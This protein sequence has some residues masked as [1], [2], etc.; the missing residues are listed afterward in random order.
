VRHIIFTISRSEIVKMMRL[1]MLFGAKHREKSFAAFGGSIF[2]WERHHFWDFAKRNLKN[3]VSLKI[4]FGASR[5]IM[6]CETHHFYDFAKRNRE[7]DV[8]QNV[9]WREGP[10]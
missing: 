5:R 4:L 10:W 8:F 6:F 3:D 2:L 7:N 1:K 9:I